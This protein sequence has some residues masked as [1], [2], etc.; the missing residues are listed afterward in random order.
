MKKNGFNPNILLALL[1]LKN[2]RKKKNFIT[3]NNIKKDFITNN[4]IKKDF[5]H[6]G[7][8]NKNNCNEDNN[9]FSKTMKNLKNFVNNNN[10]I[11]F[12]SV[13]GDNYYPEKTTINDKKKKQ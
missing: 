13:A 7:C 8:W 9:D 2:K 1:I 4:N 5:I 3:N 6:F 11:D 12:I 10:N